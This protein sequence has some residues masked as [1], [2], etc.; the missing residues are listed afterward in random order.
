MILRFIY[1][2]LF[3]NQKMI[4]MPGEMYLGDIDLCH[5]SDVSQIICT[6]LDDNRLQNIW[7][8]GEVTNFHQHSSGHLYF[9]LSENK[10]GKTYVLNSTMWRNT[11]RELSFEPKN[12]MKVMIWG[13]VQVYEPHGK[14]QLIA[15]EMRPLGRGEKHLL[16]LAW[17]KKLADE[18]LFD[19][20]KKKPLPEYPTRIGVVTSPGGAARSDI[21]NVIGR[22]YPVEI[23]VS[24]TPVQGDLAHVDIVR[25]IKN[26]DG[27]VD[28]II[29]ARGGGSFE[30]L[31]EFN[32]PDVVRAIAECITPVVSAVGHEV[33]WVLSDFAADVRAPTPSA[34]AE[35]VVPD[36]SE[37]KAKLGLYK[38]RLSDVLEIRVER[39]RESLEEMRFR[40]RSARFER[41]LNDE[42]EKVADLGER[43][44]RSVSSYINREKLL[45]KNL[46]TELV[47]VNPKQAL[48]R[49]YCLIHKGG[50]PVTS[51]YELK[52]GESVG[53][54]M[55]DGSGKMNVTEVNYDKEI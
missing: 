22:R 33:D 47:A 9:S 11:A 19:T 7:V 38:K 21:E 28:V 54:K 5:V 51:A 45:L 17:K 6:L 44:M 42:R 14:Y 25:A 16:L 37:M 53:F 36:R 20:W 30:D 4:E 55:W 52:A 27:L 26:V 49:G 3:T 39:E 12:G 24:P 23:I 40:L 2:P 32:H 41:K 10:G 1:K 46:K 34:A 29:V 50:V 43:F 35:L 8:E 13:S 31:F 48:R 15:R 18:G